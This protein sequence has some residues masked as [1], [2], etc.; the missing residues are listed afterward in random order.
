MALIYPKKKKRKKKETIDKIDKMEEVFGTQYKLRPKAGS[1]FHQTIS[2]LPSVAS[3]N[4]DIFNYLDAKLC[5]DIPFLGL[6][7]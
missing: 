4:Q 2:L 1:E 7:L 3:R 6:T 5:T